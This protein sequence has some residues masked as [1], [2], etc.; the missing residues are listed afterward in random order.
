MTL[1][2]FP[3]LSSPLTLSFSV[4]L[5]LSLSLSRSLSPPLSL[6]HAPSLPLSLSLTLAHTS[7]DCLSSQV[8]TTSLMITYPASLPSSGVY[9]WKPWDDNMNHMMRVYAT[10][11]NGSLHC[12]TIRKPSKRFIF[13]LWKW[14]PG[15]LFPTTLFSLNLHSVSSLSL[16]PLHKSVYFLLHTLFF[17]PN[18]HHK[19]PRSLE[20]SVKHWLQ[21]CASAT[22]STRNWYCRVRRRESRE[23]E[24]GSLL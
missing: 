11:G 14:I 9:H 6:S 17:S 21:V 8:Q 16:S 1:Q 13:V 4:S 5:S 18:R 7:E 10:F 12:F 24:Y 23:A 20:R 19:V 3:P 15:L 2:R 22:T